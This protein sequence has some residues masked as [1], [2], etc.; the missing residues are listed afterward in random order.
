M[1]TLSNFKMSAGT[2]YDLLHVLNSTAF[3]KRSPSDME[4]VM[5][6]QEGRLARGRHSVNVT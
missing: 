3:I 4:G 2:A 6:V 5:D 1:N